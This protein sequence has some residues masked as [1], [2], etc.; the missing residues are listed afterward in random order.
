MPSRFSERIV[1]HL[2]RIGA[3]YTVAWPHDESVK[4]TKDIEAAV[5]LAMRGG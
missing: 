3:R 5:E 2:C 1:V 4:T